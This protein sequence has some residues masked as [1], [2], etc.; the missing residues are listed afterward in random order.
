MV[1]S[2]TVFLFL[3]LPAVLLVYYNPFVRNQT[4]RNAVLLLASLGFYAWGE[5][6]FVFLMLMSIALTYSFGLWISRAKA[7][8]RVLILGVGCHVAILAVFK[9]LSFA[10]SQLGL[11]LHWDGQTPAIALPIGISFFTFQMM[12]YQFDVYYGKEEAQK[13]ILDLSLYIAFFPQLIAGPIVRYDQIAGQLRERRTTSAGFTWGMQRFLLGLGKKALLANYLAVIADNIFDTYVPSGCSVLAA[14]LGA[15]AY[16][17]QI[18][19]DFSGYS[20]MAIGLGRMFGFTFPENFNYPYAAASVT[21]FWRKWHISL[22]GWFRDYVYI[23]LGGNRVGKRRWMFNLFIVW[24]LTGIWHGANWTFLI[25]GLFY[26]LLLL[27]EK[28][29]RFTERLGAFSHVYTLLAVC[30][31]WVLFRA[32]S[33]PAALHYLG[34]MFGI[35]ATALADAVFLNY[36]A[37]GGILLL[38]AA[39]LSLPV[40]PL[41][42]KRFGSKSWYPLT[43]LG[44]LAVFLLSLFAVVGESYNPFIYFNF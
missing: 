1:F 33:V 6:V 36:I 29:T 4:F 20:D 38:L 5:P 31:A 24:L 27:L 37:N 32:E 30:L 11:L 40:L 28:T 35:C 18:Y 21:D 9:Y 39:V 26:F 43:S 44:T 7:R 10:L 14:W 42:R 16:T 12:S 15:I 19:F 34:T 17:L 25:W 22:S 8:K 23:P 41:V 3:F 2:S 13:N